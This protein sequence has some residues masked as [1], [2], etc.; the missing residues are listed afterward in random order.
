MIVFSN[1]GKFIVIA[2]V[3]WVQQ[4]SYIKARTHILPTA[5]AHTSHAPEEL[6]ITAERELILHFLEQNTPN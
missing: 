2:H 4:Y 3:D 5:T 6:H 1:N